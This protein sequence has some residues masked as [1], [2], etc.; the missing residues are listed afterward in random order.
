MDNINFIEQELFGNP[1]SEFLICIGILLLGFILKH[2]GAGFLSKQSFRIFKAFSHNQFSEIFVDL[3][4]KPIEQLLTLL[5]LYFAFDRL[6]FPESWHLVVVEKIGLRWFIITVY[7]IALLVV[8]TKILLKITDFFT[9]VLCNRTDATVSI[10]LA[11]FLKELIKVVI[12]IGSVFAGLRFIF[13][14]NITALV[15]SLGIGGL[16]VALAAQDTL[17]NLLASFIIY[18]DKPFKVG[19]TIETTDIKGIV[20]HVGFRTTRIRTVEKSL[21]TVPNKKM[22]DTALNN[23]T[24]SEIRR[25]KT[26]L[27]LTY[28]TKSQQLL[29]IIDDIKKAIAVHP[30]T[31]DDY[32]VH[33]S[34]LDSSSLNILVIY[35]V[36]GN[37]YEN[38]MRVKEEL[39]IQL[40][41]I[42]E[43][44]GCEFAFPS[45]TVYLQ[46][47]D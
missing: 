41:N 16:A 21:L 22:I 33:F 8:I 35:F 34:E 47:N 3:L 20:E 5:I 46:K 7:Q 37:E 11:N 30:D 23:I 36:N 2:F 9:F 44:H 32:I 26:V 14:V 28:S 38:M 1:I 10:E 27:T 29:A 19:D 17:S 15:A 12:V 43:Q 42:V 4:R 45:Q 24:L 13:S 39:N 31:T 18:L 40:M 25:V 6:S